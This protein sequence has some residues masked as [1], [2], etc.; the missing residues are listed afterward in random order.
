MAARLACGRENKEE[1]RERFW[2]ETGGAS[3]RLWTGSKVGTMLSRNKC[4]NE[5]AGGKSEAMRIWKRTK[6]EID[7]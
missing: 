5:G 6:E 1:R 7:L 4:K 3:V 2:R